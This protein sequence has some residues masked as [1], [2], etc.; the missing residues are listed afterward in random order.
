MVTTRAFRARKTQS[1]RARV[2]RRALRRSICS[3]IS[4]TSRI[5]FESRRE[6]RALHLTVHSLQRRNCGTQRS[7]RYPPFGEFWPGLMRRPARTS[8]LG[9]FLCITQ[10]RRRRAGPFRKRKRRVEPRQIGYRPTG[11]DHCRNHR[12]SFIPVMNGRPRCRRQPPTSK[13]SSR[14]A[15]CGRARG[16]GGIG[17]TTAAGHRRRG[18]W[19]DQHPRPSGRPSDRSG[20]RSAPDPADDVFSARRVGSN[21]SRAR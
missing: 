12:P 5:S 3:M 16:S 4:A 10:R 18:F 1:Q 2:R 7:A 13:P 11:C 14:A 9:R 8:P 20:R 21:A 19:K 15:A 17:G 6:R